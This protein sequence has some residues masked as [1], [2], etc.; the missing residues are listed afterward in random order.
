MLHHATYFSRG[1]CHLVN[2]VY[3]CTQERLN[4]HEDKNG[5][6]TSGTLF[7][8]TLMMVEQVIMHFIMGIGHAVR[9][10]PECSQR[11]VQALD[12]AGEAI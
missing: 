11:I 4:Q 7:C 8:N 10:F 1:Q 3:A 5:S 6:E 12:L 9:L 2:E